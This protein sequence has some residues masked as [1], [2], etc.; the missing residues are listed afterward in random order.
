MRRMRYVRR[1]LWHRGHTRTRSA[2]SRHECHLW[3]AYSTG[4]RGELTYY[5]IIPL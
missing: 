3:W 2:A 4:L 1:M 5:G